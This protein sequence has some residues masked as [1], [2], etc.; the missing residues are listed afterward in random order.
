M[1]KSHD[2]N[3]GRPE[4]QHVASSIRSVADGWRTVAAIAGDRGGMALVTGCGM[5]RNVEVERR[6]PALRSG[7]ASPRSQVIN[8]GDGPFGSL[9]QAGNAE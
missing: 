1:N 7:S 4:K 8:R 9:L 2:E 6:C 5:L 3:V